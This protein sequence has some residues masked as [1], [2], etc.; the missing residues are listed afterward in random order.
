[1]K[2]QNF[3]NSKMNTWRWWW[4]CHGAG[5]PHETTDI[6]SRAHRRVWLHRQRA[7]VCW[8]ARYSGCFCLIF[9]QVLHTFCLLFLDFWM[10]NLNYAWTCMCQQWESN[11]SAKTLQC[12]LDR[13]RCGK[14][15]DLVRKGT[16]LPRK[17]THADKK[18]YAQVCNLNFEFWILNFLHIK[19]LHVC[20]QVVK[21]LH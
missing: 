4:Q 9:G 17:V 15:G 5:T 14:L 6:P 13:L 12:I 8:I 3:Q 20:R 16:E 10:S 19:W 18:W 11:C 21:R 1:M 2:V 7:C